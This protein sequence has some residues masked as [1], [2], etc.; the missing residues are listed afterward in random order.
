V[1]GSTLSA[2][3]AVAP[4]RAHAR[5]TP[6]SGPSFGVVADSIAS[7]IRT[8]SEPAG[9]LTS[10]YAERPETRLQHAPAILALFQRYLASPDTA[11]LIPFESART[12]T[13]QVNVM[14]LVRARS[15][16]QGLFLLTAHYDATGK[17]TEGWD[18]FL[19]PAPGAD[20]NA[21]GVACL[22]EA[23]RVLPALDLPFD[24]GLVAFGSEESFGPATAVPLEGSRAFARALDESDTYILGVINCDMI[25]YNPLRKKMDIVSNASSLWISDLLAAA[26]DSLAP[27]L[28]VKPILAPLSANS[29]HA[30]FW[31][32]GEDAVLVIENQF[33]DRADSL[34]DGTP[35]YPKNPHYH[36]VHD[37]L[38]TLNL[39]L[40]CDVTSV[41]IGAVERLARVP[42]GFPD[43]AVD[44]SHIILQQS[45]VFLGDVVPVEV[46]V[47]N[48]GGAIA[49]KA[50]ATVELWQGLPGAGDRLGQAEIELPIASNLHKRVVIPWT[51]REDAASPSLLW[52]RVIAG[53]IDEA[54]LS[55]NE[56]SI[57]VPLYTDEILRL[58]AIG[59][60]A[61]VSDTDRELRFDFEMALRPG[62]PQEIDAV[63][64]NV[65]GRRMAT[66]PTGLAKEG[67][68]SLFW[69]NFLPEDEHAL[70][71]GVYL[72]DVRLR[73]RAS[74][75]ESSRATGKFVLFR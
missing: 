51:V 61:R 67:R 34:P 75:H 69:R 35:V 68:N 22:V 47:F 31:T 48:E 42:D 71:S 63:V 26:A 49:S 39:D 57:S 25:A 20:D 70:S 53:G 5:T 36:T 55:N 66:H 65:A 41:V 44:S 18:P 54:L 15:E 8:L 37:S 59:S 56:A 21:S 50:P 58:R 10:R 52:A 16:S 9:I 45:K 62:A 73:D 60:P 24:V 13:P 74:G 43:L 7:T 32:I 40:A 17:S 12:D 38:G 33:P 46:W 30:S 11:F 27:D 29:D 72:I 19:D 14:G 4:R 23:A 6:V 28:L 64:Y 3:H 1:L 2:A